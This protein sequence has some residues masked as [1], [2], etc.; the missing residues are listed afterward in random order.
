MEEGGWRRSSFPPSIFHPPSSILNGEAVPLTVSLVTPEKTLLTAAADGVSL[1][2]SDGMAGILPGRAPM[3]A[4]LGNGPLTVKGLPDAG[5]SG[6]K[7]W[8]VAGGFVQVAPSKPGQSS[9]DGGTDGGTV[10]VLTNRA[11]PPGEI[12]VAAART[13]LAEVS[14]RVT[15]TAEATEAKRRDRDRLRAMIAAGP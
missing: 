3:V 7:T 4:R 10:A 9:S 12:D 5:P 14:S 1:P 6:E 13:E 2:L 8:F 11:V 15:S